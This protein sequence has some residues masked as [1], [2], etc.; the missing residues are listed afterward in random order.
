MPP[1]EHLVAERYMIT[2][3]AAL[4]RAYEEYLA[5]IVAAEH[6]LTLE[7]LPEDAGLIALAAWHTVFAKV[8]RSWAGAMRRWKQGVPVDHE[9]QGKPDAR[10]AW[11]RRVN[12]LAALHR[13]GEMGSR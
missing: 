10:D 11:I 9:V 6:A 13:L 7:R 5:E 3:H 1:H 4:T 12:E 2:A 8:A